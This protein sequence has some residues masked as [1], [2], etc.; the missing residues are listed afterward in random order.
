M[1]RLIVHLVYFK[2]KLVSLD[3]LQSWYSFFITIFSI[4]S[5]C[6]C[7]GIHGG[8]LVDLS[9]YFSGCQLL[10]CCL[11]HTFCTSTF[12]EEHGKNNCDLLYWE[13]VCDPKSKH[14]QCKYHIRCFVYLTDSNFLISIF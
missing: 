12:E 4:V 11:Y 7:H 14:L 1:Y 9:I 10:G 5:V 3:M 2:S 8:M 13:L 6:F